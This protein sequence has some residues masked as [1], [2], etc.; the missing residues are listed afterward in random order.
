VAAAVGK[1][2]MRA[3]EANA[4]EV[5][6]ERAWRHAGAEL[7]SRY[8]QLQGTGSRQMWDV[9][10]WLVAGE[11]QVFR[12]M[13]R[14]AVRELASRITGY[15]R[16]TL[17]MAASVSRKVDPSI[18]I[19]GLT[20]WHHL[21]V[22]RLGA[23]QQSEWLVRAAELEWSVRTLREHLRRASGN[24]ATGSHSAELVQQLVRLR[25][26]QIPDALVPRLRDWWERELR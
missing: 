6:S 4:G 16:H 23:A 11:E 14:V 3:D 22:A 24:G 20:W 17:A 12:A 2:G 10:D 5:T 1:S 8:R 21:A 7:A 9:G 26:E 25:R 13:T 15:S 18:R 19:D